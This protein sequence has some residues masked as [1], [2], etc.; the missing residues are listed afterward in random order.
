[1]WH[2]TSPAYNDNTEIAV[3]SKVPR[4]VVKSS[5]ALMRLNSGATAPE[6]RPS[7][8][9][10]TELYKVCMGSCEGCYENVLLLLMATGI[11]YFDYM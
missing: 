7:V 4:S 2:F 10:D 5:N 1:M 6:V 3:S 11:C 8:T 9:R